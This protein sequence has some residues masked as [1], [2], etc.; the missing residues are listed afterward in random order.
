MKKI[1]KEQF[2]LPNKTDLNYGITHRY[3]TMNVT[4]IC[5]L[6]TGYSHDLWGKMRIKLE[7]SFRNPIFKYWKLKLREFNNSWKRSGYI[8]LTFISS[9]WIQ[10]KELENYGKIL[11]N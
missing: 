4:K 1:W 6:F 5:G 2:Q 10:K 11:L 9:K 3:T 7:V 8:Y